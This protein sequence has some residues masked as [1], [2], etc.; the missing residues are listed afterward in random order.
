MVDSNPNNESKGLVKRKENWGNTFVL[1]KGRASTNSPES[2]ES[3]LGHERDS[4]ALRDGNTKKAPAG[5]PL[6]SVQSSSLGV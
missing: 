3:H 4:K 2:A 6:P 1:S 5:P